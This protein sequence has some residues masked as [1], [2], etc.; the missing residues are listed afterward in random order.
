[1][2]RLTIYPSLRTTPLN[3]EV[4]RSDHACEVVSTAVSRT[5][6]YGKYE[7]QEKNSSR[8][9]HYDVGKG[10]GGAPPTNTLVFTTGRIYYWAR[11]AEHCLEYLVLQTFLS[12]YKSTRKAYGLH[13]HAL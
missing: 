9:L 13:H 6:A 8:G 11:D 5:V 10:A 1:M 4:L 2:K 3:R 7:T 12:P